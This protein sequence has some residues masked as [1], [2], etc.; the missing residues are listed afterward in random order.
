MP[1][2]AAV[3]A[4]VKACEQRSGASA[5]DVTLMTSE[6]CSAWLMASR[7]PNMLPIV[8]SG[9]LVACVA[10]VGIVGTLVTVRLFKGQG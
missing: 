10:L 3:A 4:T 6:R 9:L 8:Y 7:L 1:L 5:P 2:A